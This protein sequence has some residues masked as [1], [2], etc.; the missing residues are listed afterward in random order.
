MINLKQ[1]EIVEVISFLGAHGIEAEQHGSI[2]DNAFISVNRDSMVE[3]INRQVKTDE[4]ETY[5][6]VIEMLKQ[7]FNKRFFWT[8]KTDDVLFLDVI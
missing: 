5:K 4:E 6:V 1:S 2:W 8:N 7:R 3:V